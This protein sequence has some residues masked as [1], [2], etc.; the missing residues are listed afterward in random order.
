MYRITD[1]S[2]VST[3]V[4]GDTEWTTHRL[5]LIDVAEA[6]FMDDVREPS[7]S[8]VPRSMLAV[9]DALARS[10]NPLGSLDGKFVI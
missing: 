5:K 9:C 10:R 1:L 7:I 4:I 6:C 2:E 3:E 8:L